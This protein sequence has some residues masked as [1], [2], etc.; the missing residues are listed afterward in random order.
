MFDFV[1]ER[2]LGVGLLSIE[3]P[4][5]VSELYRV[6][7]PGGSIQL[8]EHI[9]QAKNLGPAWARGLALLDEIVARRGLAI[10]CALKLPSMLEQAGFVDIVAEKRYYPIGQAGGEPGKR[11]AKMLDEAFHH[12][13]HTIKEENMNHTKREMEELVANAKE[14]WNGPECTEGL[15]WM[16]CAKKPA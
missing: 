16:I 5:A 14:E 11:A 7:K 2:A 6:T 4:S 15:L 1:N 9:S 12:L 10:D 3:W 13:L 8:C